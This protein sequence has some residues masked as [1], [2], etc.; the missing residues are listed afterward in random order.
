VS[1]VAYAVLGVSAVGV[2]LTQSMVS[3]AGGGGNGSFWTTSADFL[4]LLAASLWIGALV[5]IGLA[6][7]RW[8][9]DLKGA[10]RTLFAAESFRRFSLLAV[11]SVSVL[12]ASGAFSAL[13]QFTA[14]EQLWETNYGLALISKLALMMPL[15]AIGAMNALY[16][17]RRVEVVG[18]RIA[19]G[20]VDST[21]DLSAIERLQRLLSQTVRVEAVLAIA[22]LVTVGVLTQLEPARA[23]AEIDA[24]RA[25]GGNTVTGELPQDEKGYFLKANQSGGL[26][27][28]LKIEPAE[29]GVNT[30]EIGLGSEFGSV[31]EVQLARLEFANAAASIAES[32]LE[33]PLA[34]SAKHR[35]EGAN[36]SQGGEWDVTA[37]I[38]RR[39]EDDVKTTF[40]VPVRGAAGADNAGDEDESRWTWP[41][42]GAQST[43]AIA[44]MVL[45]VVVTAGAATWQLREFRRT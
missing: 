16:L 40:A 31:G 43:A 6:M 7:P 9:D 17:G 23:E 15:L 28:S 37:T 44:V 4:H 21:P 1:T 42:E 11:V 35:A 27:V 14:W 30:F 33:L 12:M 8:L 2:L 22:V 38:R 26:V 3:H 34:G 13:A 29:V 10:P 32:E 39:G 5:H 24:A 36:I 18:M 20:S 41:F 45:G 19:G 25:Q